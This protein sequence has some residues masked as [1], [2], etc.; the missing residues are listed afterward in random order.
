MIFARLS[1]PPSPAPGKAWLRNPVYPL[2]LLC[3]ALHRLSAAGRRRY[4]TVRRVLLVAGA[5]RRSLAAA[6][7]G[8][9]ALLMAGCGA[10][11]PPPPAPVPEAAPEV[12]DTM[13]SAEP[14]PPL[15]ATAEHPFRVRS[16]GRIPPRPP[17]APVAVVDSALG[18]PQP[19][20]LAPADSSGDAA[21]AASRADSARATPAGARAPA[22]SS[23]SPS[24][25]A[26]VQ[27]G[28][29]PASPSS[30]THRVATG[31][32]FFG[33]ARRYGATYSELLSANPGVDPQVIR[34]GQLLRLPPEAV[35]AAPAARTHRV[36]SGETL[37]GLARRYDV[38][39]GA[40]RTA[41]RMSS[42]TVRVG[43]VLVIPK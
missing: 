22:F 40:L 5:T 2:T 37:W 28:P 4:G 39:V 20:A 18:A 6:V 11:D 29:A 10:P 36:A 34:A 43:Q 42:D 23:A 41:N 35:A 26:P 12:A 15:A 14:E 19:A 33:I 16:I 8:L 21:G 7:L 32:T 17:A 31:E 9:L 30:R 1:P 25:P 3:A 38:S 24:P 27:P 13:P